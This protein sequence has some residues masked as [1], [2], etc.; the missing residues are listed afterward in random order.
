MGKPDDDKTNQFKAIKDAGITIWI[1][2]D[3]QE[4]KGE[5]PIEISV[6]QFLF[7][8]NLTVKGAKA[9]E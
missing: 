5:F 3:I 6:T 8:Q 7:F 9:V 1:A 4:E 2:N